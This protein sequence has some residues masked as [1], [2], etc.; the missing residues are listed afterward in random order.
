MDN[1]INYTKGI[2]YKDK[3]NIQSNGRVVNLS[4]ERKPDYELYEENKDNNTFLNDSL[5]GIQ[6]VTILSKVFFSEEN[7]TR[8][9]NL[10]RYNVW[11]QSGK[12]YIVGNQS[13]IELRIIMRAVYLQYSKNL[14]YNIKE[15]ILDFDKHILEYCVRDIIHEVKQYYDYIEHTEKLPIPIQHPVNVAKQTTRSLPLRSVTSTF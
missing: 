15:Q 14:D 1:I 9:Q 5:Q 3:S 11:L 8:V 7:V 2:N 12:Q 13:D 4:N 10:V 6:D